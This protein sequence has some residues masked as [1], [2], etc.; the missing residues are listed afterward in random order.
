M[1][2]PPSDTRCSYKTEKHA[3]LNLKIN[4]FQG[5]N[6][7]TRNVAI[8]IACPGNFRTGCQKEKKVLF[9]LRIYRNFKV[10]TKNKR[11][12]LI[13]PVQKESCVEN[14]VFGNRK[15]ERAKA[16]SL[17]RSSAT[18]RCTGSIAHSFWCYI[19]LFYM[20]YFR[21][22]NVQTMTTQTSVLLELNPNTAIP[23]VNYKIAF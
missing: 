3:Y 8:F 12:F 17:N 6:K 21:F 20:F 22:Y 13:K 19:F 2:P 11:T 9:L 7:Q 16:T 23:S 1:L 18:V 14:T 5:K 4:V 10:H 15:D